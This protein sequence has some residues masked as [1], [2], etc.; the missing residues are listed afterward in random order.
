[1]ETNTHVCKAQSQHALL[2]L[3]ASPGHRPPKARVKIMNGSLVDISETQAVLI[4]R[5]S[6]L[7]NFSLLSSNTFLLHLPE[8]KKEREKNKKLRKTGEDRE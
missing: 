2:P 6:P 7:L 3:V 1:M 4:T 8:K 5:H